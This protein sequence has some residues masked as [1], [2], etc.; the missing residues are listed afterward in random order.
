MSREL[1]VL[2]PVGGARDTERGSAPIRSGSFYRR[3]QRSS[4]FDLDRDTGYNCR[5]TISQPRG[6]T[7]SD[8]KLAALANE[9]YINLETYRRDG[10]P[11]L[12]PVWFVQHG[13]DIYVYSLA[14]AGKVKRI[15]H[16]SMVRIAPCDMR[17]KLKGDWIPGT[18]R[19]V[20]QGEAERAHKLLD[21]KYGLLKKAGNIFSNL[22]K[23][24]RA[25]I[26]IVP[27]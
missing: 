18:A 23:R 15:R 20:D 22:R 8:D 7:M 6:N 4:E 11:V 16:T 21:Q 14:N 10:T 17:G 9:K 25:V 26:N 5:V 1:T 3:L 12:T 27:S 19:I 2:S 13:G 24:E